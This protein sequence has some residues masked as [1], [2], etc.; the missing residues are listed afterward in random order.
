M[1]NIYPDTRQTVCLSQ[2]RLLWIIYWHRSLYTKPG[3]YKQLQ[4][5]NRGGS[6]LHG[7]VITATQTVLVN[8]CVCVRVRVK[9][10]FQH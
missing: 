2:M 10:D 5:C 1:Y 4:A 8:V 3:K 7:V 9:I 6:L